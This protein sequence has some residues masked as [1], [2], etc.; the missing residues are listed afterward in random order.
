MRVVV[1]IAFAVL[2]ASAQAQVNKCVNAQGKISYSE[3]PCVSG[4]RGGQV[5][6]RDA[7]AAADDPYAAQRTMD[8]IQRARELQQGTVNGAVQQ[9][10]GS[11]GMV[12]MDAP[13]AASP[14]RA[15]KSDVEGCDTVSTR[16]GCIGGERGRNPTWSPNRGYNGGGGP[17]DQRYEADRPRRAAAAAQAERDAPK[18]LTN[19]NGSGCWDSSGNRYN[20]TGDGSK[21]IGP[22]GRV[23]REM[24]DRF[25][26]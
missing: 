18:W 26:C 20:R 9:S 12:S 15:A 11:G 2:A 1:C 6:G 22:S 10:Q 4:Q 17:A 25:Q 5:L 21:L 7:T 16:K 13:R 24:G 3:T 19:C 23:C 14:T 8:S